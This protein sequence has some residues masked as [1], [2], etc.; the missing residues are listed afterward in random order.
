M[1]LSWLEHIRESNRAFRQRV[2][3]A[4]LPTVRASGPAVI[5]CMDPRVNLAALGVPGFAEDGST[6][7]TVRV[8]R[9]VGG[10]AEERSL[11][12]G[13]FLANISEVVVLMHTDCGC[14]LAYNNIDLIVSRMHERLPANSLNNFKKALGEPFRER[15]LEHLKAFSDP[16]EAV[17]KEVHAIRSL[18][19]APDD[20][21]VHGLVYTLA[22]GAVEVV[23]EG[24]T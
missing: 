10:M 4:S 2:G 11:L 9:T 14:C 23:V 15:L 1:A 17:E 21:V 20:L 13:V 18:P 19:F 8:I 22:T 5:T 6:T 7:S 16:F 24:Y 3:E 12:V